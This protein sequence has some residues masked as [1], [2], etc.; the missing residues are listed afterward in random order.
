MAAPFGPPAMKPCKPRQARKGAT[1]AESSCAGMWL[2]GVAT[3]FYSTSDPPFLIAV[4]ITLRARLVRSFETLLIENLKILTLT[5]CSLTGAA[6]YFCM[7]FVHS[8]P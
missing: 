4:P 6:T 2:T 8:R 5:K 1:V 3:Q 7:F